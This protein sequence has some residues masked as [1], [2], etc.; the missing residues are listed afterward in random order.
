MSQEVLEA[1]QWLNST[2]GSDSGYKHVDETGYPGTATSQ[3]LVSALQIELN[4]SSVTGTFGSLTLAACDKEPLYIG[5]SGNKVKILQYGLYCKGYDANATDGTFSA[6]TQNALVEIQQ[7][8]GLTG[9]QL[10]NKA[11]GLCM[12]AVLG[13]DEYKQVSRGDSKIRV[14]QQSLNHNYLSYTGLCPCDGVYSRGTVTALIYAIQAEEHLPLGVANGSFGPKTKTCC[15]DIPYAQN[16]TDYSNNVYSSTSIV[17][18]TKL[19]QFAMYCIGHNPYSAL[20]TDNSKYDPGDF[21]GQFND[22]TKQALHKFQTDVALTVRDEIG[23]DEWMSLIVSTGNPDRPSNVCD[24]AT[25]LDYE[26]ATEIY[27]KG[28][29]FIGRYLTGDIVD[30]IHNVRV[31]KNLLRSEMSYIFDASLRLFV[32]F[33]DARQFYVENPNQDL[34]DYFTEARGYADAEKAFSSAKTLGVP[35]DEIIYFAVD[36]D[37]M[38]SQ[39]NSSVIPYFKGVHDYANAANNIFKVGIY[40]SRNTCTLV[41]NAGYTVSSFVSDLSTK[42][43]GNMGYA[44]PEDWAFDQI[45]EYKPGVYVSIDID[46]DATSGRYSGFAGFES[47][48]DD[49]LDKISQNGTVQVFTEGPSGVTNPTIPVYWSKIKDSSG[50]YVAKYPMYDSIPE[51][52]FFSERKHN[53]NR[54][55][56]DKDSIYYV[57]F[58]DVGGRLNAG[59]I[60]ESDFGTGM[61]YYNCSE[62]QFCQVFRG[63]SA[64]TG[65]L[66]PIAP[67]EN[68]EIEFLLTQPLLCFRKVDFPETY[69]QLKIGILPSGTKI[70]IPFDAVSGAAY[71]YLIQAIEKML[72]G[73]TEYVC[74][75]ESEPCAGLKVS[76]SAPT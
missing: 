63:G 62:F 65:T 50:K 72:P 54:T 56:V 40:S 55:D 15:P 5:I 48:Y 64:G 18:F 71:P 11:D 12:K 2:Y 38:E 43:S 23:I 67:V 30:K 47:T 61:Q 59:Y 39:V 25:R 49:K 20:Q 36:Y 53:E 21:N 17:Q 68:I 28:Y 45:A 26:T 22:L 33:Q 6:D 34:S 31:A 73:S 37:F 51:T 3:A 10:S 44:L 69:E 60:D 74:Q 41:K 75:P 14:M 4:L 1:Q 24:C 7:D 27:N 19:A 16:Q 42:Y 8:A 32:I 13:V 46:T 35:R 9:S 57:Y 76:H 70:K 52:A 58:R 29:R 66:N